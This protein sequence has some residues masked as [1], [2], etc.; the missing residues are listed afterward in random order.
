MRSLDHESRWWKKAFPD[1]TS[2][3]DTPSAVGSIVC[4]AAPNSP[5]FIIGR[6]IAGLGAA[7][8]FQ[9]SLGIIGLS[10]ELEKRPLYMGIV[11]SLFGIAVCLGPVLG[12]VFTDKV[13]WRW[14]FWM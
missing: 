12:G 9:G 10:V 8:I 2:P 3:A 4:A 1:V 5:A 14:C 6:A 11:I 13:S 7:G